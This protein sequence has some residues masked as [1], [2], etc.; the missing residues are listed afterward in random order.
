[1]RICSSDMIPLIDN[2]AAQVMSIPTSV[3]MERAGEAVARCVRSLASADSSVLI[4]AGGGNNGG[5]GYAAAV[6]L[7]DYATVTVLD[8]FAS[9]QRSE[10]GKFWLERARAAGIN[11][12]T[13]KVDLSDFDVAVDAIFGTGF[14]G[15]YP[16]KVIEIADQ[17]NRSDIK[18]VAVDVPIGVNADSGECEPYALRADVTVVLSYPKIGTLSYPAREYVGKIVIDDLGL[19]TEAVHSAFDFNSFYTD[20]DTA[21]SLLPL[22]AANGNK[23]S[24]GKVLM[25]CGSDKY[26]GAAHLCAEGALRSGAGYIM[27][28][29]EGNLCR[30]LRARFPEIVYFDKPRAEVDNICDISRTAVTVIGC[31]CGTDEQLA[32]LTESLIRTCGAPLVIDADAINALAKYSGVD[33]LLEKRREIILTPHPLELSRLIGVSVDDINARRLRIAREFSEKYGVTLLLKGAAS[34]ISSPDKLYINSSGCSALAKAGSGDVLA[35]II[36][37]LIAQ[38]P[39]RSVDMTALA[40]YLHGRAADELSYEI[41]E[42]AVTPSDIPKTVGKIIAGILKT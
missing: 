30:E 28:C 42:Y 31:G 29:G 36:A 38:S 21:R 3:L 2:Y 39:A 37:S 12:T 33:L 41:S 5:D 1:M 22:R 25:I 34:I 27:F 6:K 40:A 20:D 35:G 16:E 32:R 9:G 11:I 17:L 19:D 26:R 8:V 4:Y 14:R 23:G 7:S 18:V 24:F 13:D 10:E 15:E